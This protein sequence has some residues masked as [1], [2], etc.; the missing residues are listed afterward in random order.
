MIETIVVMIVGLAFSMVFAILGAVV[1]RPYITMVAALFSLVIVAGLFADAST[2]QFWWLAM[3]PF[4][5]FTMFG[6]EMR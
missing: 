4:V 6:V 5:E 2:Q 3:V 1:H